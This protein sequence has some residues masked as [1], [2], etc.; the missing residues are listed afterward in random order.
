MTEKTVTI[1]TVNFSREGA[2]ELALTIKKVD[3]E[4]VLVS[5]AALSGGTFTHEVVQIV[6]SAG[7]GALITKTIDAIGNWAKS[8]MEKN[9]DTEVVQILG[10]DGNVVAEVM[11]EPE[12]RR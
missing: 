6:V 4:I 9:P 1:R 7:L 5:T 2:R 10:P 8:W 11:R 12:K 3:S